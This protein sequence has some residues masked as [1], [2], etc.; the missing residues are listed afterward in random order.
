MKEKEQMAEKI[1][2]EIVLANKEQEEKKEKEEEIVKLN[3]QLAQVREENKKIRGDLSTKQ[4]RV[5]YLEGEVAK[6]SH[7]IEHDQDKVD[8]KV[9]SLK[10]EINRIREENTHLKKE[11]RKLRVQIGNK[12]KG[13]DL[14]EEEMAKMRKSIEEEK[15]K[16]MAIERDLEMSRERSYERTPPGKE[17]EEVYMTSP[18]ILEVKFE[19]KKW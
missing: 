11:N 19:L 10:A 4:A 5:T 2:E 8:G 6:M 16:L 18:Y 1:E 9:V 14:L 3:K 7:N 17:G 13:I 15:D 12:D